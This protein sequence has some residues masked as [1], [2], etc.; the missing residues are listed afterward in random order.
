MSLQSDSGYL[1]F[2]LLREYAWCPRSAYFKLHGVREPATWSMRAGRYGAALLEEVLR[3]NG[4]RGELLLEYPLASP[5]LGLRGRVDAVLLADDGEAAPV[6]AKRRSGRGRR[7]LHH[8]V[9]AAAY[10]IAVEETMHRP[11][12]RVLLVDVE[13]GRVIV[14]PVGR[15]LRGLAVDMAGGLWAVARSQ[16]LPEATTRGQRCGSCFYRGVCPPSRTR[17]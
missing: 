11:C 16:A 2:T 8:R 5:S 12:S 7:Y 1:S 17:M 13:R 6:E 10:C 9:Q 4:F 15:R 14:E 3:R